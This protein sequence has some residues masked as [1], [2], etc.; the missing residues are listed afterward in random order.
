MAPAL[1]VKRSPG[2]GGASVLAL[3]ACGEDGAR[4]TGF[5]RAFSN[6]VRFGSFEIIVVKIPIM[7]VFNH[8]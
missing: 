7:I 5:D 6:G 3:R 1:P 4:A 8:S 2:T